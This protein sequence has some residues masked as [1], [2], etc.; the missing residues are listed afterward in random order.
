VVPEL[1]F[2]V[3]PNNPLIYTEFRNKLG[4]EEIETD[5]F[6]HSHCLAV[7]A[8]TGDWVENETNERTS[9]FVELK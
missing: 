6:V 4:R 7:C 1:L 2:I 9:D 8:L 3:N 5:R